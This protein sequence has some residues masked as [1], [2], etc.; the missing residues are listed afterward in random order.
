[1][2]TS[3]AAGFWRYKE[4][5]MDA[6]ATLAFVEGCLELGVSVFDHAAVYN[7]EAGFG[8]AIKLKPSIRDELTLITKCGIRPHSPCE[9]GALSASKAA[10]YDSSYQH[11]IWSVEQSLRKLHTDHLDILLI[12]RPDYLMQTDELSRAVEDLKKSGLISS[13]GVSNCNLQQF[14]LISSATPTEWHQ[15]E[16][17]VL[18][19]QALDNGLLNQMQRCDVGS[20]YWSPLA[21]GKVLAHEALQKAFVQL[22]EKYN[23]RS[24]VIPYA[25]LNTYP[26]AGLQITGS[27]KLSRIAEAVAGSKLMLDHDDWYHLLELARGVCVP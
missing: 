27:S 7:S 26:L 21:G 9:F 24:G 19:N 18:N 16:L 2:N 15:I 25:W 14:D 1:M 11:I 10:H 22:A 13:F 20:M 8:K 4:W 23:T 3:I 6:Q 12:H 17:S 5:G